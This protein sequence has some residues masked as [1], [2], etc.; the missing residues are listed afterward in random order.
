MLYDHILQELQYS[1]IDQEVIK[2]IENEKDLKRK[3]VEEARKNNQLQE[4]GCCYNDECLLEDMLPCREGHNFCIECVQRGS[5][6][7]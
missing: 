1:K 3:I 5:E 2:H 6:V 4:C 7:I